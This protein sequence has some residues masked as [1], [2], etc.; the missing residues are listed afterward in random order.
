MPM[1][2]QVGTLQQQPGLWLRGQQ[3]ANEQ[4]NALR[5]YLL[6]NRET[7]GRALSGLVGSLQNYEQVQQQGEAQRKQL[8]FKGREVDIAERDSAVR[9]ATAAA[10]NG[11]TAAQTQKLLQD[12]KFAPE[13][14]QASLAQTYAQTEGI[15]A[16]TEATREGTH[17]D[18]LTLPGRMNQM[19]AQTNLLNEQTAGARQD[20]VFG[21]Q[22][23]PLRLSNIQAQ[24]DQARAQTGV[25][26]AQQGNIEADTALKTMESAQAKAAAKDYK[27]ALSDMANFVAKQRSAANDDYDASIEKMAGLVDLSPDQKKAMKEEARQRRDREIKFL[28]GFEAR[29]AEWMKQ[30]EAGRSPFDIWLTE[31]GT[32]QGGGAAGGSTVGGA[33]LRN[34]FK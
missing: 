6:Q 24:T 12:M 32:F 16:G 8:E 1:G 30:M 14:V 13:L 26:G 22:E 28:D 25:L 19:G 21:A 33:E 10:N 2:G 7:M 31:R 4:E 27:G 34:I 11:L 5:N 18:R 17:Q 9:A 15:K 29:N 23:Q 20:R 3:M